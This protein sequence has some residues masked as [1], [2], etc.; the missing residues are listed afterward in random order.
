MAK[1]KK[2]DRLAEGLKVYLG[3]KE[4]EQEDP[5]YRQFQY[6]GQEDFFFVG[7]KGALRLGK[8]VKNSISFNTSPLYKKIFKD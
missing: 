3:C 2:A 5:K 4:V 8:N 6:P 1:M 7:S